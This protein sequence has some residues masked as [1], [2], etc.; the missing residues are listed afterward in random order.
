VKFA[1]V[2]IAPHRED[3]RRAVG[4]RL[5]S[6]LAPRSIIVEDVLLDDINFDDAFERAILNK[7]VATQEALAEFQRIAS[8]KNKAS[9]MIEQARGTAQSVLINATAQA[10]ANIALSKSITPELVQY[11]MVTKLSPNV[12]TIMMPTGAPF[13]LDGKN[14]LPPAT[15]AARH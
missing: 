6:E 3:I 8:E 4:E 7:Q 9:Q 11:Q 2:D 15:A 5:R 1:A 14:L 13:I 10:E 12:A